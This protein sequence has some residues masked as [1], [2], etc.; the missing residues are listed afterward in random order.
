MCGCRPLTEEMRRALVQPLQAIFSCN[1][2]LIDRRLFVHDF[3]RQEW[4]KDLMFSLAQFRHCN[5]RRPARTLA[6]CLQPLVSKCRRSDIVATK[7]IRLHMSFVDQLLSA[8]PAL[9][10]IHVVRD[11]RG[12]VASWT[13]AAA[14]RRRRLSLKQ[15]RLNARLICRRMMTDCRIRRQLLEPK[16]PRRIL[17]VRYEDLVASAGAV[18]RDVYSGLLQLALPS[19]VVDVINDQLNATSANGPAG[20]RRT[21]GTA[22]ATNWRRTIDTSLLSYTT[23]ACRLLL[24]EL[25]YDL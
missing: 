22:T 23:Q 2:T 5:R 19:D 25:N 14:R 18:V 21:N 24:A 13:R 7:V 11:P 9:R 3:L 8:D 16:Y 1:L 10:L 4:T 12:M 20:T 15:M 6:K 17:V